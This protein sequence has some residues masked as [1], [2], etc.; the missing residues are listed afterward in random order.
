MITVSRIDGTHRVD[1]LPGGSFGASFIAWN[2][3][4]EVIDSIDVGYLKEDFFRRP[5]KRRK[6]RFPLRSCRNLQ[7][8][9]SIVLGNAPGWEVF[10][11]QHGFC[12]LISLGITS[13][14]FHQNVESPGGDISIQ[15]GYTYVW[16]QTKCD[17]NEIWFNAATITGSLRNYEVL[18]QHY[19]YDR[20]TKYL[21]IDY[22]STWLYATNFQAALDSAREWVK[23]DYDGPVTERS[24]SHSSDLTFSYSG[25]VPSLKSLSTGL[26]DVDLLSTFDFNLVY[27][28]VDKYRRPDMNWL[29]N[30]IGTAQL[31]ASLKGMLETVLR[32]YAG[33]LPVRMTL[34]AL[35]GAYLMWI[36]AIRPTKED[37]KHVIDAMRQLTNPREFRGTRL[38]S[39]QTKEWGP[40]SGWEQAVIQTYPA[41]TEVP[42][43]LNA[44]LDQISHLGVKDSFSLVP[45]VGSSSDVANLADVLPF[46]PADMARE[47]WAL[48]GYSFVVD[49]FADIDE[50]LERESD[51]EFLDLLSVEFFVATAKATANFGPHLKTVLGLGDRASCIAQATKYER[52]YEPRVPDLPTFTYTPSSLSS[53]WL[54]GTALLGQ[55]RL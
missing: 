8:S 27:R 29:E 48:T 46:L 22:T 3:V 11:D 16:Y 2:P 26:F 23:E 17:D 49:W 43:D 37:A 14:V 30:L 52:R 5:N 4:Y 32:K 34:K 55:R 24:Y 44:T 31:P 54:Q 1:F 7:V 15:G 28:A 18:G 19:M 41:V 51:R 35:C 21:Y 42:A 53:I 39:R 9:G 38:Q 12:H 20:K 47:F 36:Y 40:Y 13:R 25:D 6:E 50:N 45:R 33:R 10:V